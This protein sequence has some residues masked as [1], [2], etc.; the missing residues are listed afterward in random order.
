M[1]QTQ[2]LTG[3]LHISSLSPL[4]V[5]RFGRSLL[6]YYL[7]FVKKAISDGCSREN[8]DISGAVYTDF[9]EMSFCGPRGS[10]FY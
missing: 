6:F 9:R 1:S 10:C 3:C 2:S 7:E 4:F 5:D 8:P